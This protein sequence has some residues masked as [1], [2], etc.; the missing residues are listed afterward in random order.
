MKIFTF[1]LLCA[2]T[3]NVSAISLYDNNGNY[4]GEY[5][6]NKY[7]YN[8]TSNTY[9]PYGSKYSYYSINNLYGPNGSKYS[10]GSVNNHY[11][12]GYN[13]QQV[14]VIHNSYYRY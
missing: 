6:G 3:Y 12:N 1:L 5:N 7:D 11:T 14:P 13:Q 8:S 2:I 10:S 4:L 9:G